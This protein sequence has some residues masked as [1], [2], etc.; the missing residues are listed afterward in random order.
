MK[1]LGALSRAPRL[2]L[3][4]DRDLLVTPLG[5]CRPPA[6]RR[7]DRSTPPRHGCP[8]SFSA[9]RRPV[10]ALDRGLCRDVSPVHSCRACTGAERGV[11]FAL[12]RRQPA[13]EEFL[14]V[15]A[16]LRQGA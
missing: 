14:A 2:A 8:S 12:A 5:L 10:R 7:L 11:R 6:T 9:L 13:R 16:A 1:R 15:G 4:L 3:A